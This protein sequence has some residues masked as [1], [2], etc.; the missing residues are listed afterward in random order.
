M[1]KNLSCP[2][3]GLKPNIVE[4]ESKSITLKLFLSSIQPDFFPTHL[5]F[6]DLEFLNVDFLNKIKINYGSYKSKIFLEPETNF[7]EQINNVSGI[8]YRITRSDLESMGF[9]LTNIIGEG[10]LV[11][12]RTR[13]LTYRDLLS[14][15]INLNA[16]RIRMRTRPNPYNF[17][18]NTLNPNIETT[19]NEQ[20]D[21]TFI[22]LP[23]L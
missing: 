4:P 17:T 2:C 5:T 22:E 1:E 19:T 7:S 23:E 20:F 11:G 14:A 6:K 21:D 12:L 13:S 16:S 10:N 3:C 18:P 9:N 15:G 8:L